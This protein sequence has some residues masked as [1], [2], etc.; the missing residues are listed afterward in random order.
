VTGSRGFSIYVV[1][2]SRVFSS[3]CDIKEVNLFITIEEN[4]NDKLEPLLQKKYKH[5]KKK[6]INLIHKKG[7]SIEHT[8]HKTHTFHTRVENHSNSPPMK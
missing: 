6:L 7:R 8:T 1:S 2:Q 5:I 4:I 3:D